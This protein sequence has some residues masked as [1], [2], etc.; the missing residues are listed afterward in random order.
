MWCLS[1]YWAG[2]QVMTLCKIKRSHMSLSLMFVA[3]S[4]NPCEALEKRQVERRVGKWASTTGLLQPKLKFWIFPQTQLKSLLYLF[5]HFLSWICWKYKL[6][7]EEVA[8]LFFF[9]E[10]K[11]VEIG[12][13]CLCLAT[14]IHLWINDIETQTGWENNPWI[15]KWNCHCHLFYI[16][17][18]L[19][20]FCVSGRLCLTTL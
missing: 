11:G 19:P 9:F 12:L 7:K 14:L 17:S 8:L 2:M 15:S 20:N 16:C 5:P 3:L 18:L 4:K 1:S 6:K 13:S 10:P